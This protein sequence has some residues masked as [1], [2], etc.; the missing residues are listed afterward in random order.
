MRLDSLRLQNF[1]NIASL[2]LRLE[3]NFHFFVGDNGQG[4]TNLLEAVYYLSHLRSFRTQ[5][6]RNLIRWDQPEMGIGVDM[7]CEV[8]QDTTISLKADKTK[9]HL[10]VDGE[11]VVRFSDYLGRLPA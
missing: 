2:D 10:Q 3:G 5:D 8:H 1:R 11:Q 4:K 7:F 9:R 6:A